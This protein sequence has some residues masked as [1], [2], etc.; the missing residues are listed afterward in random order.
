MI[1]VG[2]RN[3]GRL[4]P[5]WMFLTPRCSKESRIITAFY[6]TQERIKVSGNA[7][8]SPL[9]KRPASA[10]ATLTAE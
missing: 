3:E 7:L 4:G 6:S 2:V 1:R 8:T 10:K 9:V 5:S